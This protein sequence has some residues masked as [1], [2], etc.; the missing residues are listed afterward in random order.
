MPHPSKLHPMLEQLVSE[1]ERLSRLAPKLSATQSRSGQTAQ[2]RRPSLHGPN[3]AETQ[4]PSSPLLR[5]EPTDLLGRP[6]AG[7]QEIKPYRPGNYGPNNTHTELSIHEVPAA[8]RAVA[9][10]VESYL[11]RG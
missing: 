5:R 8:L 4:L 9:D 7:D 10:A 3:N 2:I 6:I 1:A 11:K